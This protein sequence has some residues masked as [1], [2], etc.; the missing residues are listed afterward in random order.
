MQ[1]R[2]DQS[3]R[4]LIAWQKGIALVESVYRLTAGWPS[5]ERLGLVAQ[6]RRSAVSVPANI[7][8]GA[9]RSGTREFRH[10]LSMAHGSLCELETHLIVAQRLGFESRVPANSVLDQTAEVGRLLR[11]LIRSLDRT[12]SGG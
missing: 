7:A 3:Y 1:L 11:G 9:G 10:H 6:A 4:D 8:E 2:S 12:V 5:D